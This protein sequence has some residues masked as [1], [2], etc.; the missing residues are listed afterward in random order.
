MST[1]ELLSFDLCFILKTF[2]FS[3][4]TGWKMFLLDPFLIIF[5]LNFTIHIFQGG[6]TLPYVL[7]TIGLSCSDI[8]LSLVHFVCLF[9]SAQNCK[10]FFMMAQNFQVTFL[11]TTWFL[12]NPP[13][14]I[15]TAW[16]LIMLCIFIQWVN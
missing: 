10:H 13:V 2:S 11:C 1:A 16:L 14:F 12:K 7:R 8:K 4:F 3:L 5:S 6:K 15:E 9:F